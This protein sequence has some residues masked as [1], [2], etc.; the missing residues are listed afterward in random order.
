MAIVARTGAQDV[1]RNE[2]GMSMVLDDPDL[3]APAVVRA[4]VQAGASIRAVFDEQPPLEDVYLR[5]MGDTVETRAAGT[6]VE[7]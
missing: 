5:L 4:L 3:G 1:R 2:E 6:P 7:P